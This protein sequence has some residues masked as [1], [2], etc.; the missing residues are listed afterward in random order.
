M[1]HKGSG[2]G[3]ASGEREAGRDGRTDRIAGR[4]GH[5]GLE[6]LVT[7]GRASHRDIGALEGAERGAGSGVAVQHGGGCH[8]F[9]RLSGQQVTAEEKLR[10][11]PDHGVDSRN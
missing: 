7:Q 8:D 1:A 4:G 3:L 11:R 9:S 5:L 2:D 10:V 6:D